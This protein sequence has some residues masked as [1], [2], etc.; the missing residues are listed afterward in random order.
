[1]RLPVIRLL[2]GL[3]IAFVIIS[4]CSTPYQN[5]PAPSPQAPSLLTNPPPIDVNRY[6]QVASGSGTGKTVGVIVNPEKTGI[7]WQ[8]GPDIA[9]I[10]EWEA[11]LADGTVIASGSSAPGIGQF[12]G[13][14]EDIRGNY[15]IV[16]ARFSDGYEQ[17]LVYTQ[18]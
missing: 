11:K 5:N 10:A 8:G 3:V 7:I 2:L 4:G 14:G 6:V 9:A 12:D 16:T 17:V 13:F 1:M 15:L 18:V